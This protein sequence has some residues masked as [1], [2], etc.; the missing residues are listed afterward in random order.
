MM[1]LLPWGALMAAVA[2]GDEGDDMT[3]EE[4]RCIMTNKRMVFLGD[5]IQRYCAFGFNY[6]L[7]EG[8]LPDEEYDSDKWGKNDQDYDERRGQTWTDYSPITDRTHHRAWV[9]KNFDDIN[10]YTEFYFIQ[11]VW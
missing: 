1:R 6:W 9:Y 10:A 11:N 3:W 4:A 5:S 2:L 8:E 7:E